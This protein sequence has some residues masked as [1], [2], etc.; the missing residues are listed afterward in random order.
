MGFLS[1]IDTDEYLNNA[2]NL[3]VFDY[4]TVANIELAII[5][6]YNCS[7]GTEVKLISE[8]DKKKFL[9]CNTGA[10]IKLPYIK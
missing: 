8:G 4:N 1:D 6:I 10:E 5:A 3:L 2:N 7:V 9:D